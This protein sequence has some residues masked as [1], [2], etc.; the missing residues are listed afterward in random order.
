MGDGSIEMARDL[1]ELEGRTLEPVPREADENG[2]ILSLM[3][4]PVARPYK[5]RKSGALLI[6][7]KG[8]PLKEI[9]E[10]LRGLV[11]EGD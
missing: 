1:A 5:R 4:H 6:P 3:R 2:E 9:P 8:E 7:K 10:V 11:N